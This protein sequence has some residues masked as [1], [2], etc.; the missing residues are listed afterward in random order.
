MQL[1]HLAQ[2]RATKIIRRLE[3]L[4]YEIRLR[5]VGLFNLRKR[6]QREFIMSFHCLKQAN[7]KDVVL[8]ME[9]RDRMRGSD[10]HLKEGRFGLDISN[11][12]VTGYL[13]N[14]SNRFPRKIVDAFSLEMFKG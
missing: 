6:L 7:R 13:V 8:V 3:H 12:F 5:E 14:Y 2:R 10:F 4:C 11:K 1:L 9:C